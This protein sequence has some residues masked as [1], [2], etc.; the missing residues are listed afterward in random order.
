MVLA[1]IFG[2]VGVRVVEHTPLE[3]P[4]RAYGIKDEGH[5]VVGVYR[6]CVAH[7]FVDQ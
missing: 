4:C 6:P 2:K 7:G 1:I 5:G 3:L